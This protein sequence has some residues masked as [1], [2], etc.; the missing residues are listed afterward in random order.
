MESALRKRSTKRDA[1]RL[2]STLTQS[3]A[4]ATNTQAMGRAAAVVIGKRMT[5]GLEAMSRP[6]TADYA[7]FS[8]MFTEKAVASSLSGGVMAK[9]FGAITQ[10]MAG[11]AVEQA[12]GSAE[13]LS[14]IGRCTNPNQWMALQTKYAAD[15]G[16]QFTSIAIQMT[17]M[18]VTLIG[19]SLVPIHKAAAANARRLM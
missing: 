13:H 17:S 8:R 12:L 16:A 3:N 15:V 10:R 11:Y 1:K 6:E 7:E 4:I 2:G 18:W 19:T 5:M 9:E 14:A